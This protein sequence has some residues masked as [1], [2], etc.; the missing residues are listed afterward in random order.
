MHNKI[1]KYV[2]VINEKEISEKTI[3][4]KNWRRKRTANGGN[5]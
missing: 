2:H 5:M 1:V 3:K 4:Y